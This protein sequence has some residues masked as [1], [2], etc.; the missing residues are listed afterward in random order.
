[1]DDADEDGPERLD[2]AGCAKLLGWPLPLVWCR[3]KIGK[4]AS[5]AGTKNGQ[6]FWHEDEVYRWAASTHPWLINR[7]PIRYWPDAQR[8]AIYYGAREIEDAIAQT[9]R[10]NAGTVCLLW[11]RPGLTGPPPLH[12]VAAQLP[13]ADALVRVQFDFHID[14]PG[15][16][17]AQPDN[18]TEWKDFGVRWAKL[19][20]VLGQ[21][22]PYWPYMLR[23]PKL[24][25]AWE[26]GAPPV[27]YPTIPGIDTTPLLRLAATLPQDNPAH[28][29][30]LHVAR[31][32]QFSS[33]AKA[34]LELQILAECEQRV[35][36][37]GQHQGGVTVVAA[38][39]LE[40]PEVDDETLDEHRRRA[41]WLEIFERTDLLA[42]E[43]V[44]EVSEWDGG[45]DFPF[46]NPEQI[47]P[48][49]E[50]GAEWAAR[51]EP[52]KRTAAFE[53]IDDFDDQCET[54]TDPK[55]G[56][57]VVR[58]SDGLLLAAIPQRLGTFSPLAEVIL[59]SPIWVRTEDG[60]LYPAPKDSYW[61]LSWGYPGSGPGSLALLISRLL[62]DITARGADNATGAPAGLEKLTQTEWPCGT[63][64]TRAQLEAARDGRPYSGE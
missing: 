58:E 3:S 64:L 28:Q 7:V 4:F 9:W 19:A 8:P 62:D 14:G 51:L 52:I 13:H 33:T 56:A 40:V 34:Q 5:P 57:P 12:S 41:G 61:G 42:A 44:R 27:T 54:L 11:S 50:Y 60:T 20:Q 26:P 24:I 63:V 10:T 48:T 1:V 25:A 16:S 30:L 55:T 18:L 17:T 29:V 35:V 6:P 37:F 39:P 23:I 38:F 2:Q 22:V 46:S 53:S 21:P 31:I 49:T 36:K 59:D 43:C 15:L 45:A 32:A 47:D